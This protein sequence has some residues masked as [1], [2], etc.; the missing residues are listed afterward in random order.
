[1][2]R[3]RSTIGGFVFALLL[4]VS[5]ALTAC[6]GGGDGG[7]TG[8]AE[9]VA[10]SDTLRVGL[11]GSIATLDIYQNGGILDYYITAIAQ[12]SLVGVSNDGKIIPALAESWTTSDDGKVW[13]FRIR[14]DAKFFDGS[15]V[16]AADF[17]F[18]AERAAD[19]N[20]APALSQYYAPYI[21]KVEATGEKEVTITLDGTHPGFLWNVSNAGAIFVSKKEFVESAA[22]YGSPEDLII[23]SGP[24]KPVEFVPGDHLT[25]EYTDTW[26]GETPEIKRVEFYFLE[27]HNTRMLAFKDK[28]IDFTYDISPDLEDQYK[29]IEGASVSFIADRSYQGLTFNPGIEPFDDVHVRRAIAYAID[30]DSIV[31]GLLKGHAQNATALPAPEQF[32]SVYDARRATELLDGVTHYEYD[33]EKAKA[34]LAQSKVK[35]GFGATLTYMASDP[36]LGKVSLAIA[37][38]LKQIG[39]ELEVKEIPLEQWLAEVGDGEQGVAWMSYTPTTGEPG[40]ITAWLLAD[41]NP[42]GWTNEEA[43]RLTGEA[44]SAPDDAAQIDIVIREN[45]IAQDEGIYAPVYWGQSGIVFAEGV[46]FDDF[47]SYSLITYWPNDFKIER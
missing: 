28:K 12:E 42:A 43:F 25:F 8:D 40:E 46:S 24:Y 22:A 13:V 39:I 17:V 45:S 38:N 23:G 4:I 37:E 2:N 19:E 18:S 21:E 47:N 27:D 35:D 1:M 26:W 5:L 30:N 44:N 3:K 29:A 11:P 31:T 9:G 33:V 14:D 36:D 16:T 34:E 7:G 10:S 20:T 15:D 41:T 6:G 32:A